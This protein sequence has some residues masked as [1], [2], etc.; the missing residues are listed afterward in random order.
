MASF[1]PRELDDAPPSALATLERELFEREAVDEGVIFFCVENAPREACKTRSSADGSLTFETELR[2]HVLAVGRDVLLLEMGARDVQIRHLL[3]TGVCL[4]ALAGRVVHFTLR[5][6]YRGRGRATIDAEIRDA[7]GRLI[8]WAHDGRFPEDET[9]H[10]L[11]I[12]ATH[13]LSEARLAVRGTEGVVTLSWPG[14]AEVALHGRQLTMALVRL[15]V[16]DVGFV[17]LRR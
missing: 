3:P 12:R 6:V 13:D 8:L 1:P 11:S 7:D 5:Q 14:T 10:G 9:S 15:A 16:D 2:G 4:E 17:V